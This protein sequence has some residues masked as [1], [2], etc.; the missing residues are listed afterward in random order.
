M[1]KIRGTFHKEPKG[2]L[3]RR[4]HKAPTINAK[5]VP[6][7]KAI[8]NI[9]HNLY[10]YLFNRKDCARAHDLIYKEVAL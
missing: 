3:F 2:R 4:F 5:K 8:Y 6:G 10:I 7:S 1:K 9:F